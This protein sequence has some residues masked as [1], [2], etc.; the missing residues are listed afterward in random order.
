MEKDSKEFRKVIGLLLNTGNVSFNVF[1]GTIRKGG[2]L[3]PIEYFFED[4]IDIV[5]FEDFF[6]E[7]E[8]DVADIRDGYA[9]DY[10]FDRALYVDINAQDSHYEA[11]LDLF[12]AD[13]S[14]AIRV[15]E[16]L[17]IPSEEIY[18]IENQ[19]YIYDNED[20]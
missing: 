18:D 14:E 16:E 3:V 4:L 13:F 19:C 9:G 20:D 17:D 10:D 5:T 7:I 6:I 15:A 1:D 2:Y 12:F 11:T 8:N